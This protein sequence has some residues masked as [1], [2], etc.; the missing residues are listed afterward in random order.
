MI[1]CKHSHPDYPDHWVIV[2]QSEHDDHCGYLS[3]HLDWSKLWPPHDLRKLTLS[4]AMHDT[5]SAMWED[6]PLI[7]SAGEPWTYWTMPPDNHIE[8]HKI[9]VTEA[10]KALG[11]YGA[12]LISMHVVGIHRDRLHIDPQPNRWHIPEVDTPK[13]LAFIAEQEAI[14]RELRAQ[15][16]ALG[17]DALMNDFKLNEVIDILSTQLSACGFAEREMVYVPGPDGQPFSLSVTP[18]GPWEMRMDPFLFAGDR[19]ECAC[20]GRCVPKRVYRDDDDFREA[21]YAAPRVTLPYAF[22]R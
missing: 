17:D 18:A 4:T 7:N 19:F 15:I 2:K 13:V 14:Q 6:Y 9:G 3:A 8:L 12:L 22:V 21:W 16:P 11:P 20:A 10:R 1:I 5:G